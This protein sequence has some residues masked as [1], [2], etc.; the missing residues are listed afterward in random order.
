[1]HVY[2]FII[3]STKSTRKTAVGMSRYYTVYEQSTIKYI[4]YVENQHN[5]Y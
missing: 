2:I 4:I 5:Q 3:N 1:M